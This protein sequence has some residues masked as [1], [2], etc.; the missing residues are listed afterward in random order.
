MAGLDNISTFGDELYIT[1]NPGLCEVDA[2]VFA[3]NASFDTSGGFD[4][5][6]ND[7]ICL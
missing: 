1:N 5:T 6:G 7:A 4:L 2:A 3:G